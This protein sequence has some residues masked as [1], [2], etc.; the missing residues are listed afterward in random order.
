MVGVG[1]HSILRVGAVLLAAGGGA[2]G[3]ICA[4]F[5]LSASVV[6]VVGAGLGAVT[7]AVLLGTGLV[8]SAIL[9]VSA[10][11]AEVQRAI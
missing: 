11:G 6:D 2:L 8:V 1:T 4:Q 5:T 9:S 7:G 3:L 10:R